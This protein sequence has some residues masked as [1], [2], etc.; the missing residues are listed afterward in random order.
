MGQAK[1]RKEKIGDSYDKPQETPKVS[2]TLQLLRDN[3]EKSLPIHLKSQPIIVS[4][5]DVPFFFIAFSPLFTYYAARGMRMKGV[6]FRLLEYGKDLQGKKMLAGFLS[7]Q[8][9]TSVLV[10]MNEHGTTSL[11]LSQYADLVIAMLR[12]VR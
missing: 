12:E 7:I 1:R 3:F 10:A 4:T 6:E 2:A 5:Y 8:N 11:E 9:K